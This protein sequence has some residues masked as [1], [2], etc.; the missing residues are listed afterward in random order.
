MHRY[1]IKKSISSFLKCMWS[2]I[3]VSAYGYFTHYLSHR[4]SLTDYYVNSNN[5]FKHT[6]IV[7]TLLKNYTYMM[8]FHSN[9]HHDLDINKKYINIF[10]EF[11]NNFY[12]QG[13]G[14]YLL[15]KVFKSIDEK[16]CLIWGLLYASFHNINYLICSP[17]THRDHH[18]DDKTNFGIDIY[19]IVFGTKYN[20]EDIECINHYS[21]NLILII[22][23]LKIF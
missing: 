11:L 6:P 19:D 18:I 16:V 22:L 12:T 23:L 1:S 8:D 5:I 7:Q 4:I 3:F 9:I 14:I 2:F 15:L 21:F 20:W 13:I 10:Y 17:S